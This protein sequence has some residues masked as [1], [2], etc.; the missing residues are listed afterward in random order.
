MLVVRTGGEPRA[1]A[2]PLRDALAEL[3]RDLALANVLTMEEYV[4]QFFVGIRVFNVILG[5]FG[6][7]ALLLAALGT[8][9]VLAYT[10]SLRRREIGIRMAIGAAPGEVVGMVARQG[11]WLGV[12]GLGVGVLLTLPMVGL[13]ASLLEGLSTV[14]PAT[15]VVIGAVLFGVTVVAS[16]VPA[17]R[18]SAIQPA[19][20]LSEE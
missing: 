9:G 16:L 1:V 18:A 20:T 6:V 10:V 17:M 4:E 15:L 7:V 5:G 11:V 8:Y 2:G 12:I 14:R 19:R 13:I 3:D